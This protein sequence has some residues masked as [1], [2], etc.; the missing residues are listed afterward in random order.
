MK[1]P[2]HIEKNLSINTKN[3][4]VNVSIQSLKQGINMFEDCFIYKNNIDL[5]VY[6]RKCDHANGKL[7]KKKNK[8]VCP[9]HEWCFDPLE[10]LYENVA[11]KKEP[12][13]HKINDEG[14]ILFTTSKR[15]PS[16][17]NLGGSKNISIT[18]VSH[19]FIL[20]QSEEFRFA[21][22]P[23][24]IGPAFVGGWWL[25]TQPI[26]SWT[27]KL[28]ECNFI[29]ISH[30]HPD[31]LNRHTLKF[32]RKDMT[33]IIPNFISKSVEKILIRIGFK[34]IVKMNFQKFYKYKDTHLFLTILKSG[35]FRDDSGLYFTYGN[36]SLFSSVDANNINYNEFPDQAT[37]FLSSFAGG[38]SGFPLCHDHLS[39]QEKFS[40]IERN[41]RSI[42]AIVRKNARSIN[43]Q[44]F[45]PYAGFFKE[46]AAR[47][48]YI[49]TNNKKNSVVDYEKQLKN[50]HVL[51]VLLNNK[52]NFFGEKLISKEKLETTLESENPEE[53]ISANIKSETSSDL[54]IIEYFKKSNFKKDLTLFLL[55][56]D[57]NFL[58]VKKKFTIN[59]KENIPI[60]IKNNEIGIEDYQEDDNN[61]LSIKV[62]E[63]S[64]YYLINNRLPWENL[65][66]GFQCRI[67]RKP[68]TYKSEFWYH[69]TNIYF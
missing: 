24:A 4:K 49:K 55:L 16:L 2:F 46:L 62:R 42:T 26:K 18:F 51:N 54:K 65:S 59:F 11:I 5:K 67:D 52:F 13:E 1:N 68:E 39:E 37:L 29:Y 7:I 15:Q 66:I 23:W 47:D 36:F 40:I 6:D 3:K 27:E 45:M 44:Y 41:K 28:N 30:N 48:K 64:F 31:H 53:W 25:A 12:I 38:A 56:T 35:D 8:M 34:N 58:K 33:F 9:L 14:E 60:V 57:D 50:R 22:D 21:M 19:A 69:F 63:H 32:V 17:P 43:A 20:I 61:L 10:G